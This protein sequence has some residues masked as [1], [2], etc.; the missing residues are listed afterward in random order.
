MDDELCFTPA[1]ELV[2]KMLS[3]E[4]SARELMEAT[5]S[6][7]ERR[8]PIVNA[9]TLVLADEALVEADRADARLLAGEPIKPLHGL[10]V[11]MK[12]LYEDKVGIRT[13]MGAPEFAHY[14]PSVSST[15]IRRLEAAGAII[16][17]KTN[18]PEFGAHPSAAVADN[19]TFG[20]TRSPLALNMSSGGSSGG[21]AAAVVDG[22]CAIAQGSDGGG[23]LRIPASLCGA[24]AIKPTFG[25]V[26]N[27]VRPNAF[28]PGTPESCYGPISRT[29]EDAA[30]M[31]SILHGFD[32]RDPHAANDDGFDPLA[33]L[34]QGIQGKRIAFS[35]DFGGIPVD[36]RVAT[37][38]SEA[39]NC[40][41]DAGADI[42]PVDIE[43]P[44]D[45]YALSDI[46]LQQVAVVN[47]DLVD[48]MLNQGIDLMGKHRDELGDE[49]VSWVERGR[50]MSATEYVRADRIRTALHDTIENV[51]ETFDFIVTPTLGTP[52]FPV[53]QQ[54]GTTQAPTE[55][56]GVPVTNA[57][58]WC[59]TYPL[60]FTGHPAASVPAGMSDA[61]P[62]GMQIVGRRFDDASVLAASRTFEQVRPWHSQYDSLR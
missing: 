12:D 32:A 20:A 53:G 52:P 22:M 50:N 18:V 30:L 10:P 9:Y 35:P 29:V 4:L 55:I 34:H 23:S 49:F 26:P 28:S 7:I 33:A 44:V 14:L 1:S 62:V 48:I 45:Q 24:Y 47:A 3:K 39:V 37:V 40:L 36:P 46:W 19:R 25:R 38:V 15:Y 2:P 31:L 17:G 16:V 56:N 27:A 42:T 21:S 59:L 57:I 60:N 58:G 41:S 61:G 6:R 54:A 11:C 13:S 43:L 51:F 8:N 5:L